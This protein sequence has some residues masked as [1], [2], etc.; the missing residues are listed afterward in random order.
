[1]GEARRSVRASALPSPRGA[2][3]RGLAAQANARDHRV[4]FEEATTVFVDPLASTIPDPD[5]SQGE[6]RY[7]TIE[8]STRHR[9]LVVSYTERQGRIRLI[10]CRLATRSE[11]RT[12]EEG[13][14]NPGR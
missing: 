10:S 12:Y 3:S 7:L 9:L 5:H 1:M 4:T 6:E 11:R 8:L 2:G 13:D 14:G